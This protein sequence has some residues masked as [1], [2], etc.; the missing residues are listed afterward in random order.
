MTQT[1]SLN[2]SS[3]LPPAL[4]VKNLQSKDKK[5]IFGKRSIKILP[6]KKIDYRTSLKMQEHWK[7]QAK[8]TGRAFFMGFECFSCI[9]LGSRGVSKEDLLYTEEEYRKRGIKLAYIRRGG[10]ATLHSPGQLVI[11]PVLDLRCW[12][13]KP[14]DFL[15]LLEQI[16]KEVLKVYGVDCDYGRHFAGL[17]TDR[18]KIAFFGVHI[19]EGVSQHGLALNVSNDLTLFDVIRSCGEKKRSHDSFHSRG[20]F[21][22]IEEVFFKWCEV[23]HTLIG[24]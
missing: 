9:T 14:R 15:R 20:L 6:L 23:A 22:S 1:N 17:F 18:G 11:Y 19:S 3:V 10:Q 5:N 2:S 13:L 8:G 12:K 24:F 7:Q 4:P 16:T 21:P